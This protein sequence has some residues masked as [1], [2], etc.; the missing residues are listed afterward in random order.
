MPLE[1]EP[2]R[3]EN[4]IGNMPFGFTPDSILVQFAELEEELKE[5]DK[6]LAEKDLAENSRHIGEIIKLRNETI[7][8]A[9]PEKILQSLQEVYDLVTQLEKKGFDKKKIILNIQK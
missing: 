1:R 6:G 4:F 5:V 9:S 3:T 2:R 7:L 8:A